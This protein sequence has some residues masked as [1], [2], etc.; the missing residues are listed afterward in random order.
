MTDTVQV[1]LKTNEDGYGNKVLGDAAS[2]R[3]RVEYGTKR[4]WV[5]GEEVYS[6]ARVYIGQD[7]EGYTSGGGIPEGT[8][9]MP[10]G[11]VVTTIKDVRRLPWPTGGYSVEIIL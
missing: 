2:Y 10:D 7:I 3:A 11:T 8:V 9:T 5:R 6:N 4:M 1:R